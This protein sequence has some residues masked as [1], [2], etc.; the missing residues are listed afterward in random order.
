MIHDYTPER[1]GAITAIRIYLRNGYQP[2]AIL[3]PAFGGSYHIHWDS[4]DEREPFLKGINA[5]TVFYDERTKMTDFKS[6][7]REK[8]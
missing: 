2:M 3:L 8:H 7:W 6:F 5:Y 4:V 1:D